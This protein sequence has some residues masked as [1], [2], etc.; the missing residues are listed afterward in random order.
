MDV[1]RGQEPRSQ[2]LR[3]LGF[4]IFNHLFYRHSI[5]RVTALA[6]H[7]FFM[8]SYRSLSSVRSVL[9]WV[10]G[11]LMR[12]LCPLRKAF[13]C[14]PL[15]HSCHQSIS[16]AR[17]IIHTKA[18]VDPKNPFK[19]ERLLTTMVKIYTERETLNS[20]T[21]DF[22]LIKRGLKIKGQKERLKE[23]LHPSRFSGFALTAQRPVSC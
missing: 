3:A 6:S 8:C 13:M 14:G 5:V 15:N 10:P 2:L 1:T 9:L 20:L 21:N 11:E 7:I 22:V 17:F 18:R 12:S 23:R 4:F 19:K 16:K